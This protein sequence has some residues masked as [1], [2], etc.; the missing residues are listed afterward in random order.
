MKWRHLFRRA[1]R[2]AQNKKELQF[3]FEAETEE[4][5]ARG[6]SREEAYAAARKA[7]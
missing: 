7:R 2:L 5:L 6:M 3:H 1:E 4:N